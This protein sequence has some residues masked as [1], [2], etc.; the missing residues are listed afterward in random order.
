MKFSLVIKGLHAVQI[1]V[2]EKNDNSFT[3]TVVF[4]IGIMTCLTG[5]L[6]NRVLYL[7]IMSR[8]RKY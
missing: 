6:I 7:L 5:R 1:I 8:K 4:F 2:K 3:L